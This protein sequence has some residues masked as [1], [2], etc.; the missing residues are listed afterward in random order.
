MDRDLVGLNLAPDRTEPVLRRVQSSNDMASDKT[1]GMGAMGGM[2]FAAAASAA[3]AAARWEVRY[4]PCY[5][6]CSFSQRG[7]CSCHLHFLFPARHSPF[8]STAQGT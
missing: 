8:I 5:F 3:V 1:L 4:I 6:L 7:Q 2:G